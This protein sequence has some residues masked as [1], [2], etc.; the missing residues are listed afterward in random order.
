MAAP[1]A[2]A[3]RALR[4]AE[5]IGRAV[6]QGVETLGFG[7][8]LLSD[9]LVAIVLGRRRRQPVRAAPIA[10]EM[11]EMGIGAIPIVSVLSLTIGVM[12][13]MQGIHALE[14]F[15]AQHQVTIGVALS[16]AREFGPL[17]TGIIF[18]GR[19]GSALAARL[20]TMTIA[21]EVDA[22]KVMGIHPVRFLVVPP[23]VAMVV[24][25]PALAIW[26]DLVA[27]L[28][29]GLYITWELGIS[30]PA[31][32]DQTL[33]FLKVDDVLH[34][35]GKAVIFGGLIAIVAVLNGSSASGGAAGVGRVTT[36]SV[37]QSIAAIV[38]ADMVF[39]FA[40]IQ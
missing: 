23:L 10:A 38:L 17:I 1:E 22:L 8:S 25:L 28:G 12:L 27:L 18:A 24:M 35:V 36:S 9:S 20:G 4:L 14:P 26:S 13:A 37:V 29:A 6:T 40:S 33:S 5:R 2:P 34:G 21:N 39:V 15:G 7:A 3:A 31:Y 32:V 11:M 30:F 16:V 19:S